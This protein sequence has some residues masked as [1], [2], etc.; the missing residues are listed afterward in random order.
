M[1]NTDEFVYKDSRWQDLYTHLKKCGFAVFEP[2][3]AV[4]ECL[5]PYV[6]VKNDGA[7]RH[8]S[9]STDVCLYSVMCYVPVHKYSALEPFVSDVKRAMKDLEPLFKQQGTESASYYDNEVKAHMISVEY[10]NYKKL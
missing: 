2:G 7:S 5:R 9:F 10:K 8:P 4:G 1:I 3:M 6:V